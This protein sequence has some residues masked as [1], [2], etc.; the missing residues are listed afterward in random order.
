[1]PVLLDNYKI[2]TKG[3]ITY[4]Q[5]TTLSEVN[6][7]RFEI[8]VSYDNQ[9]WNLINTIKAKGKSNSKIDYSNEII[10]ALQDQVIYIKVVEVDYDG[11]IV[12][13]DVLNY[14]S[15]KEN[16][17]Q[18]FPNPFHNKVYF[19]P[20]EGLQVLSVKDLS[21]KE[22]LKNLEIDQGAI[23]LSQLPN[24]MYL[25]KFGNLMST[26]VFKAIKY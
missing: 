15:K 6:V 21:N 12:E 23:D 25:I 17:Q 14:T 4:V 26:K 20:K 11:T 1:M 16:L 24:G 13:F 2:A 10:G 8:Y 7:D 19:D 9:N 3:E 18:F 5:W 22:Y